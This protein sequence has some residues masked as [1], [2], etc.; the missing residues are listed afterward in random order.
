MDNK[1]NINGT[2]SGHHSTQ[3]SHDDECV[4]FLFYFI[5]LLKDYLQPDYI[6]GMKTTMTMNRWDRN[7]WMQHRY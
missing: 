1:F 5:T 4:V 6:Y 3:P 2:M 7:G